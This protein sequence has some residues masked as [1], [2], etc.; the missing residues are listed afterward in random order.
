[1]RNTLM[2]LAALTLALPAAAQKPD[3]TGGA[4]VASE[5]GKAAVARTVKV[6]A[7]VVAIDKV[8][9]TVTLKGPQGNTVEVVAGDE[10]KNFDQIKVGDML[11]VAYAQ[12]LSLELQK[13]KTGAGGITTQSAA[14]PAKPDERPAAAPRP[15]G[16]A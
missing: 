2:L 10:V 3:V 11:V 14:L 4:V 15:A 6:T 5:P 7:Q 9:R 8:T 12:A 16:A 1:M 13:A